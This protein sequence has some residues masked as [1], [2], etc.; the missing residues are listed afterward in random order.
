MWRTEL[1][2]GLASNIK[3]CASFNLLDS[4]VL[5]DKLP[6]GLKNDRYI[7][8]KLSQTDKLFKF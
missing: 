6:K 2:P 8:V 3:L 7:I 5:S 1:L 4:N